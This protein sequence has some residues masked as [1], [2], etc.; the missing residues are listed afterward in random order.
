MTRERA[1][2]N[3]TTLFVCRSIDFASKLSL[4]VILGAC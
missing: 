2:T 4:T 3:C 1:K